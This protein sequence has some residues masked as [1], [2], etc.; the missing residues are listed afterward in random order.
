MSD[1]SQ[2]QFRRTSQDNVLIVR[3]AAAVQFCKKSFTSFVEAMVQ[4]TEDP[5]DQNFTKF[6]GPGAFTDSCLKENMVEQY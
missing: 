6:N 1:L 4:A 5:Y 2:S 3:K